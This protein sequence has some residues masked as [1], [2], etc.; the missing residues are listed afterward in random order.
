MIPMSMSN[1]QINMKFVNHLQLEWS[2]FV[3]SAKQ[4]RDLHSVNFDQLYAF[5]K[6][7]ERDAKEVRKMQKRFPKPLALLENTYNPP[8]LNSSHQT[9]LEETDDCE[10]LQLQATTNFKADHVDAY[11]SDCDDEATTNAIFMAICHLLALSMMKWLHLIMIMTYSL[12]RI[13]LSSR[14]I[15]SWEQS[16]IKEVKEMKDIFEQM[17]DEVDQCSVAKKSFENEK[18][19]LL[20]NND[21]L[22]EENII[23][24]LCALKGKFSESQMNHN[25][26][27]INTKLSKPSTLGT[28]LY[29]VTPFPKSKVIPKVVKKNDLSKSL[30]SHLTTNK[31]IGKCTKVLAPGLLKIETK[32]INVYFKNNKVV[33]IDYLKVN[34]EH[35]ATL[36]ELLEEDR[37]LIPL[38]EHIGRV[39]STNASRSK[40][41]SN[42]KNDRIS[43]PSSRSMKNKVEAHNRKFKS[44]ANKKNHDSN[45]NVNVKNVALLKNSDTI[46]LSCNACL[47][48]ANHDACVIVEI[49]LWYLDSGCFKHMT[50]HRDKLI[51]FVS[52]FIGMVRFDN[53]HFVAIMGYGDLQMGYILILRVYYVEGLGHNLFSVGQF[54]DSDLEVAFRKHTCFVQNLEGVDLLSC[55]RGSNLY[56]ISMADMMNSS[57][58]FLH[59][60]A[61]KMKSWLWHRRLSHLNFGTINK[62]AKQGLVKGLS[63]LKY[64]KDYLCSACQMG[65]SKKESHPHKLEPNIGITHHTSIARTPQQNG[66][67][68]RRNRTLVEA[69]RTMLIFSKSPLY[70]WAEA[71]AT[72]CYTQNR[73]IIYTRY[74]KTPY[75]MLRDSKS[76]LKYLHVFEGVTDLQHGSRPELHGLTF[77]HISSGLVLNQATST[78]VKPPTMN[79]WDLLFP[80]MFDEYFKSL[81]DVSTPIS[82][83]TLL[84]LDIAEASSSTT[85]DQKAPSPSNSPN[86][87]AANSPLNSTNVETNEEAA[88]FDSDTFTNP[89]DHLDTSSAE[90]SSRILDTLNMHTFQQPPIYTKRWTKDHPFTTIIGDPSKPVSIR[91][92]LSTDDLWCYF[93]TFLAKEEPKNYKEAMEESC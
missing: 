40:P 39:S 76:E 17:E 20:I 23:L 72:T 59:F 91:R 27:S 85:I 70:L 60:K 24:I 25:G 33:H 14:E 68:E 73:S 10:D 43:Q 53:D 3:T 62:L 21:R 71:V 44:S 55:S 86:I 80:P 6:H 37:T 34:K 49:V 8:P 82:T 67:V 16:N 5:L 13:T 28:K 93:H 90:L 92:Q 66:V 69:A 41:K 12:R 42:T 18:K 89:F 29:S 4:A 54:C 38:D 46:C 32:P 22:L 9:H 83:A 52:K 57:P 1:M 81:S 50:G 56:T 84:P 47:F 61:S 58:I 77:G 11:D 87:K 63:K 45:C 75:E 51:N 48:S 79:D 36:H 30:N 15:G 78:S 19:Q 35:V 2:M 65:K 7:N 64:T 88:E 31:I 74:N 26:T